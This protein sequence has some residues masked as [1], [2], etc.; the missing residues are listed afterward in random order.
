MDTTNVF[1]A[2]WWVQLGLPV[3]FSPVLP[4]MLNQADE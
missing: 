2:I 4:E 1:G 3:F